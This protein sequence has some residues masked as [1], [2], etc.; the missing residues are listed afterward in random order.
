MN[1]FAAFI[2]ALVAALLSV[3]SACIAAEPF[4]VD[5]TLEQQKGPGD[6][7]DASFRPASRP[8]ADGRWSSRFRASEFAGLDF[9]G[10]RAD[11]VHPIR[12]ALIREA[13]RLDCS[14]QG[15]NGRG[16]GSCLFAPDAAFLQQLRNRGIP[17]PT[18]DQSFA[19]TAVNA[20]RET[21]E[22]LA[23]AR[24]PMPSV[25]DLIAL[26]ALAVDK[27]YIQEM[28]RTGYRPDS[29]RAL[30]EFKALGITPAWISAFARVGYANL[31]ADE[32]VQLKAL[33][34][35][36]DY[37][38]G[39]ERIGYRR[40]TVDALVQLKALNI[41][42]EFVRRVTAAGAP[43]PPVSRLAQIRLFGSR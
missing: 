13:G 2:A 9:A 34:I 42:P 36:P 21:I 25:D 15:G 16:S 8:G 19:L 24:Y 22:A 33:G 1:R 32:L 37:V 43:L 40:L 23:A 41:T 3:S 14:G 10:F 38:L 6:R 35:T 39:F 4:R 18:A 20:R 5:F 30:I 31:A 29:V 7:I 11:G 17:Q 27:T 12:F 28:A 26:S